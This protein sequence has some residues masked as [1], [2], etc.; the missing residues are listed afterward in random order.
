MA[1]NETDYKPKQ[2]SFLPQLNQVAG[3]IEDDQFGAGYS[4]RGVQE[5]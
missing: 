4:L 1:V 2:V 5:L 3:L